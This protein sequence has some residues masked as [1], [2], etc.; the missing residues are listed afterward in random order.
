LEKT[1]VDSGHGGKRR[2]SKDRTV[3]VHSD[4]T[5]LQTAWRQLENDGHCTVFQTYDWVAAW[6]ANTVRHGLAE[7][8][9]V[10]VEDDGGIV[11]ILPLCRHRSRRLRYISLADLGVSDYGGPLMARDDRISDKDVPDVLKAVLRAL[12]HCDIVQ[13]SKLRQEIEGK[14][15]PLLQVGR[16]TAMP[17]SSYAINLDRPWTELSKDIMRSNLRSE[18]RRQKKKIAAIGP[19]GLHRNADPQSIGSAMEVLWDM[20]RSRFDQIGRADTPK[21]W[22]SFYFDVAQD[23]HRRLDVSVTILQV[24][25]KPVAC[26]FGLM[27]G[28]TYHVI[29]PTFAA[30]EWHSFSPGMLMFDA[31]LEDFGP[32]TGYAGIFDF[33]IGDE[34]YKQRFGATQSPLMEVI[35]PQSLKGTLALAYRRMKAFRRRFS[36]S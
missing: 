31:M 21:V 34:P 14:R 25:D 27:R 9:I 33:T 3:A 2:R 18:I 22:Q 26:C 19:L 20:R 12:P 28:R 23:V 32:Q 11:W 4:W 13:F 10:T 8:V 36:V 35:K 29:L 1:L 7:P 6:Y 24:A 30:A 5:K 17:V 15:N 16:A